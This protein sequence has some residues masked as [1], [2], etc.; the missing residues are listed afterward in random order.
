MKA[1][2]EEVDARYERLPLDAVEVE[3]VGVSI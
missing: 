1:R 3:L 2:F